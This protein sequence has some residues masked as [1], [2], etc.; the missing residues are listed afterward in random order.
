M[1]TAVSPSSGL[2]TVDF[3]NDHSVGNLLYF[4]INTIT[5]QRQL[6]PADVFTRVVKFGLPLMV[7]ASDTFNDFIQRAIRTTKERLANSQIQKVSLVICSIPLNATVER[8]EFVISPTNEVK[9]RGDWKKQVQRIFRSISAVACFMKPLPPFCEC[10]I[11]FCIP[12]GS[13]VPEDCEAI[14]PMF[15]EVAQ[16]H[17]LPGANMGSADLQI[18]VI[19]ET[20]EFSTSKGIESCGNG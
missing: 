15:P 14:H 8:W 1:E 9:M 10:D 17:S 16:D 2:A 11:E 12:T 6:Y 19:A 20:P 7:N 18:H 5:Y 3:V 4:A 13:S